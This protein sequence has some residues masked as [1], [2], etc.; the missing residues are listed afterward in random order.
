MLFHT[1]NFAFFLTAVFLLFWFLVPKKLTAQNVLLIAASYVFYGFWDV[2]FLVLLCLST[3]IDF[4]TGLQIHAASNEQ[5]RKRWLWLSIVLNFGLLAYFKYVNFFIDNVIN[6]LQNMG[7]TANLAFVNVLLPVGISF[8][9]FHGI[10]YVIDI[11]YKRIEPTRDF[12]AYALFV[13]FFPLLVAGPIERA[14]H[15]LPQLKQLRKFDYSEA[16]L[17]LKQILWGLFKKMVIADNCMVL[18]DHAFAY[19]N[20]LPASTLAMGAIFF[21]FQI[22]GDFSGYSDIAIGTGRLFGIELLK[23]FSFPYF[24]HSIADFWKRWHIS[25]TSWFR[26]YL[27]LPLG[28]SKVSTWLSMRNVLVVFLVSGFWHGASWTFVVW[29]LLNALF[30]LFYINVYTRFGMAKRVYNLVGGSRH[31]AWRLAIWEGVSILSTFLLM[32]FL[33][34]FFRAENLGEAFSFIK[35][36]CHSSLFSNVLAEPKL[37]AYILPLLVFF[38]WVEWQGRQAQFALQYFMQAYPKPLR[39]GFYGMLVFLIGMYM[40][41]ETSP[42]IY[43]QF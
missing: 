33:W 41:V 27:F 36:I 32:S 23:N 42:F 3:L 9:T 31:V 5:N 25:L 37:N 15:L 21:S 18:V 34:I 20:T 26:D 28:G 14:N 7:F 4:F 12:V 19:H 2:R 24:A 38:L 11:Y 43:F 30:Y 10:S 13:S 35:H 1:Q 8:Y 40:T 6:L 16:V 17:G 29:G 22:Y 39:W